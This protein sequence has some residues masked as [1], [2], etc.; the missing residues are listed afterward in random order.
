MKPGSWLR[1][2][3]PLAEMGADFRIVDREEGR[4]FALYGQHGVTSWVL[5]NGGTSLECHGPVSVHAPQPQW[6]GMPSS[7]DCPF[8]EGRCYVDLSDSGGVHVGCE[9]ETGNFDDEVIWRWLA[10]WYSD[11]LTG[12]E[13]A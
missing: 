7:N 8:L 10:E 3:P 13:Q 6:E 2:R 5:Y 12:G 9:W 1:R 4:Y 11:R